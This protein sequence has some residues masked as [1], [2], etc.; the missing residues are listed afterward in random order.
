[1][2]ILLIMKP[3]NVSRDISSFYYWWLDFCSCFKQL[4]AMTPFIEETLRLEGKR[5][6]MLLSQS[7]F[8]FF[9]LNTI[10]NWCL[11]NV[12]EKATIGNNSAI[13]VFSQKRR[14]A[15]IFLHQSHDLLYL[16]A[17]PGANV[18]CS[19]RRT[20]TWLQVRTHFVFPFYSIIPYTWC[21]NDSLPLAFFRRL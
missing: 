18:W 8:V 2:I 9:F 1:M 12:E 3:T 14:T 10:C 16:L 15:V 5:G 4:S 20:R 13:F 21:S 6:M 7:S 11:T 19:Q 17:T